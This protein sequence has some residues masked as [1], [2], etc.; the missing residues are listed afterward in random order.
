MMISRL[1]D[2]PKGWRKLQAQALRERDSNKLDKLI[3]RL[4]A[5]VIEHEQQNKNPL[6]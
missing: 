4:N 1:P 5:L 6:R 3:K 2:E